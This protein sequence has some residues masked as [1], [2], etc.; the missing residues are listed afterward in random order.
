MF[1][2]GGD[3]RSIL[4]EKQTLP[5]NEA[6]KVLCDLLNGFKE[7]MQNNIIHRDLKPENILMHDNSFK[8]A[9]FG[10]GK[11]IDDFSKKMLTSCVGTP[12]Y[13]AP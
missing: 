11:Q 1:C 13:M 12:L 2:N 4:T 3:F 10:F 8:L 5:E 6:K 7:L 9:D